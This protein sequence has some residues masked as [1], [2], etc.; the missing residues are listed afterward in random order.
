MIAARITYENVKCK[1]ALVDMDLMTR[2]QSCDRANNKPERIVSIN[3]VSRRLCVSRA[4]LSK[5]I[6]RGFA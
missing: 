6:R 3:T 5:H 4:A 2:M 1:A